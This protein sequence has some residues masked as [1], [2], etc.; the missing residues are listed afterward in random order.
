MSLSVLLFPHST[1][2]FD[3]FYPE[4]PIRRHPPGA[5][6][7]RTHHV[8]AVILLEQISPAAELLHHAPRL[9]QLVVHC[10]HLSQK[11]SDHLNP[12]YGQRFVVA[13]VIGIGRPDTFICNAGCPFEPCR[14][15]FLLGKLPGTRSPWRDV[16]HGSRPPSVACPAQTRPGTRRRLVLLPGNRKS[17]AISTFESNVIH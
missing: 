12:E 15:L 8:K 2:M 10:I 14:L 6:L 16:P 4:A 13:A 7:A 1:I 5:C 17:Y 9:I 3:L 11:P